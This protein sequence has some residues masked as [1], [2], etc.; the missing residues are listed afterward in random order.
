[1]KILKDMKTWKTI[2]QFIITILTAI[3]SSFFV[4]SCVA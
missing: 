1:M 3:T 4:Q 2:I